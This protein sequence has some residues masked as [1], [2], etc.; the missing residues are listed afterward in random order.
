MFSPLDQILTDEEIPELN[1]LLMKLT[2]LT[3]FQKIAI[4]KG[5][6][7]LKYL[8]C[9]LFFKDIKQDYF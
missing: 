6:H 1:N 3:D 4:K 9:K 5:I 7:Y 8:Y 2:I